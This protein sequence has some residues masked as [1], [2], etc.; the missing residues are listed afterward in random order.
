ML[1]DFYNKQTTKN[2]GSLHATY[3]IKGTQMQRPAISSNGV[4]S[5]QSKDTD[6][7]SSP[8]PGSSAQE[9]HH[10]EEER[11]KLIQLVTL[12]R[13]EDLEGAH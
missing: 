9:S 1:Y 11:T 12:A 13:E 7:R 2:A 4:A 5:Q 10:E 8:F 3:L 6:M